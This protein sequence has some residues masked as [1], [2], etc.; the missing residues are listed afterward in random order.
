[1]FQS[2]HSPDLPAGVIAELGIDPAAVREAIEDE[3]AMRCPECPAVYPARS[4][5]GLVPDA[6]AGGLGEA[7]PDE[8]WDP[9]AALPRA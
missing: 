5:A 6:A 1:M 4:F 2:D 3:R 8:P 9:A 7:A